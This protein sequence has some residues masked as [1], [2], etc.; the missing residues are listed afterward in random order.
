M[1]DLG[2]GLISFFTGQRSP[3][4]EKVE[5]ADEAVESTSEATLRSLMLD[6]YRNPRNVGVIANPSIQNR[7][8]NPLCGDE[9]ELSARLTSE[10]R[11]MVV[12]EIAFTSRGCSI[13]QASA[14]M[15]TELVKGRPTHDVRETVDS[16]VGQLAGQTS[17][18]SEW[19]EPIEALK[20]AVRDYP[21]RVKC[22][23]LPWATLREALHQTGEGRVE[24]VLQA[25]EC[26]A[27]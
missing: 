16:V 27:R 17:D 26:E 21:S 2:A 6:H 1:K 7:G 9:V 23:L 24:Y 11:V 14:S 12:G 10:G 22:A 15:L 20:L 8:M 5:D 18:V 19:L 13:V 4:S 25:R 3:R